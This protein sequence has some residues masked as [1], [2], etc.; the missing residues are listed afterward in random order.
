MEKV[1]NIA[2]EIDAGKDMPPIIVFQEGDERRL[3]DGY[4]RYL[5]HVYAEAKTILRYLGE[6]AWHDFYRPGGDGY[7]QE[8]KTSLWIE[9]RTI[10]S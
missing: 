4:R 3:V 5:G 9:L 6:P 1:K 10:L 2:A 8:R 7:E